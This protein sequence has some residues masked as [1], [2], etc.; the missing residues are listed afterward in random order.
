[1]GIKPSSLARIESSLG[2]RK[3]SPSL[4]TLWKYLLPAGNGWSSSLRDLF[5][6]GYVSQL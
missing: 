3:H 1:M 5:P 6:G 2:D 4:S